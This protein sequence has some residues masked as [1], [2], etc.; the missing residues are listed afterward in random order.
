LAGPLLTLFASCLSFSDATHVLTCF[1][2]DGEKFVLELLV[3]IF[4]SS[5]KEI[6]EI[7]DPFELQSFLSKEFIQKAVNEKNVL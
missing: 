3:A 4:R 2:L 5:E 1:M 6:L 7:D